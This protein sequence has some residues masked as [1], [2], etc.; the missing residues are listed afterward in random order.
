MTGWKPVFRYPQAQDYRQA[1][2][3]LRPKTMWLRRL[4]AEGAR[5]VAE[6]ATGRRGYDIRRAYRRD[7]PRSVSRSKVTFELIR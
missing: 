5:G 3:A 6:D 2:Q 4:V 1:I 7:L